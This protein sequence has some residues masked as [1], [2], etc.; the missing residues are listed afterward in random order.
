KYFGLRGFHGMEP[1]A[2]MSFMSDDNG[3]LLAL[4][5]NGQGAEARY[6]AGFHIGFIQDSEEQVNPINQRLRDDGYQ[7]P[8]PA[9]LHDSWTFYFQ[10]PGG[11]TV[12]VLR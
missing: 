1:R 10:A 4:F 7:V 2:G 9:R 8:K 6:P 12:E 5:R 3:M 11:F